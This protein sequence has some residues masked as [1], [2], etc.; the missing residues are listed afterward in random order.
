MEVVAVRVSTYILLL[1]SKVMRS[2]AAP[3]E[4]MLRP[5]MSASVS[6]FEM[7]W[8]EPPSPAAVNE[9]NDP[10]HTPLE[11]VQTRP[12]PSARIRP[13][14]SRRPANVEVPVPCT[15]KRLPIVEVPVMSSC[16]TMESVLPGVVV[17]SPSEEYPRMFPVAWI[18]EEAKILPDD[19]A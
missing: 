19:V 16:P 14:T 18:V 4:V 11:D 2:V 15:F 6:E 12:P 3:V 10:E 7:V 13:A 8:L 1:R 5:P 9:V 17:P